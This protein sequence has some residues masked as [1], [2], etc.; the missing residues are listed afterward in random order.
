[1]WCAKPADRALALVPTFLGAHEVPDEFLGR[2]SAYVD[3]VIDEMLPLVTLEKLASFCDVFCEPH[4]F[5]QQAAGR[6]LQA[7]RR[8]GL[9]LRIHADQFSCSGGAMLAADLG[10]ATADHLEHTDSASI[11]ALAGPTCSRSCCPALFIRLAPGIT[12]LPA[13]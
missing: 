4:I 10:A 2:T 9:G 3:L 6:I 8:L 7:A 13:P 1:M 5:D 11:A 12:R